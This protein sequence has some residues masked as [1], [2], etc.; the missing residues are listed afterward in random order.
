MQSRDSR[1]NLS[2]ET[3]PLLEGLQEAR[4]LESAARMREMLSFQRLGDHVDQYAAMMMAMPQRLDQM[5]TLGPEGGTRLKLHVP[6]TAS[7][8]R[9]KNSVAVLVAMLLLLT[10]VAFALPR[11]VSVFV[12]SVW[13]GRINA[14]AFVA[15]AALLLI[16]T[17]RTR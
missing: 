6:E 4:L 14:V 10:A 12:G 15:C 1:N 8:R 13:A 9:Q 17:S 16:A 3:D 7:H 5:L 2:P 11:V